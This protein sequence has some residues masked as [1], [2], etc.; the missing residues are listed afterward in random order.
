MSGKLSKA[1]YFL[2][3]ILIV[4]WF[5]FVLKGEYSPF[6]SLLCA[7]IALYSSKKYDLIDQWHIYGKRERFGF[8]I[9]M[10]IF[11]LIT[12]LGN[13]KLFYAEDGKKLYG[14]LIGLSVSSLLLFS[15]LFVLLYD[16][17]QNRIST[18]PLLCKR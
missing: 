14:N 9:F 3:C 18:P 13:Y 12:I 17:F 15:Y 4:I 10:L 2:K 7:G 5:V 8:I 6:I 11:S 1:T 16:V